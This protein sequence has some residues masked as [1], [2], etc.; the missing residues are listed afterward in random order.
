[1]ET[2]IVIGL[3][4]SGTFAFAF[5]MAWFFPLATARSEAKGAD[6][7]SPD[8]FILLDLLLILADSVPV[9]WLFRI[10]PDSADREAIRKA[11]REEKSIRESFYSFLVCLTISLFLVGGLVL[12]NW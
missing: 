4:F 8:F 12:L 11:W 2:I 7:A 3:C 5:G 9:F 6:E 1:M 10:S